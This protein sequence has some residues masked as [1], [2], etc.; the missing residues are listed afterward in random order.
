MGDGLCII[1]TPNIKKWLIKLITSNSFSAGRRLP[2]NFEDRAALVGAEIARIEGRVLDAEQQYER[3]IRP[4]AK[5]ASSKMR[6]SPM[7]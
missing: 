2:E 5:C 7:S 4:R 3:A 1:R 6:R